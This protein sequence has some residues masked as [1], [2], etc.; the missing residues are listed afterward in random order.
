MEKTVF[1][2]LKGSGRKRAYIEAILTGQ[3]DPYSVVE[4]VLK[5]F[6]NRGN[7]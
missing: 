4:E 6:F 5:E 1:A 3:S 7:E 2:G